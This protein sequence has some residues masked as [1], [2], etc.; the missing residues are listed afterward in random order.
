MTGPATSCP[1]DVL[2]LGL[3]RPTDSWWPLL[4]ARER[5][6]ARALPCPLIRRRFIVRRGM[7]KQVLAHRTGLPPAELTIHAD[8]RGRPMVTVCPRLRFSVSHRGP[9]AVLALSGDGSR[10]G[11][12][13]ERVSAHR[14]TPRMLAYTLTPREQHFLTRLPPSERPRAFHAV[15]TAKEAVAKAT[16]RDLASCFTRIEVALG[17]PGNP[18]GLADGQHLARDLTCPPSAWPITRPAAPLPGYAT[19]LVTLPTSQEERP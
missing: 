17:P 3:D 16:G 6:R 2:W 4:D 5:R 10:V 19:A 11:V 7:V 13:L 1:P 15:W 9:L 8:A 12:D 14:V 18:G